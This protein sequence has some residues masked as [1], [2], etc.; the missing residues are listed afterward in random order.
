MRESEAVEFMRREPIFI[1]NLKTDD[2]DTMS[3]EMWAE[4][5]PKNDTPELRV[6][7]KLTVSHL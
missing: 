7:E 5:D 2:G 3:C 6:R 4:I 1:W